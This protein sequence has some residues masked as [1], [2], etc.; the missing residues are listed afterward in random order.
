MPLF[1]GKYERLRLIIRKRLKNCLTIK[2]YIMKTLKFILA[3]IIGISFQ[4][5]AQNAFGEIKGLVKDTSHKAV[6]LAVVKVTQ[7]GVIMGSATTDERGKYT[8]KP[9]NPGKYE[10][11]VMNME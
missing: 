7:G 2:I 8:V 10:V 9:L 6:F 1:Y 3:I 5:K 11:T 4:I